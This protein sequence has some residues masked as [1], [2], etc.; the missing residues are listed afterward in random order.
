MPN[1]V[2]IQ[3]IKDALDEEHM[4]SEWESKFLNDIAEFDD[5]RELSAAQNKVLN[6]IGN[7]INRGES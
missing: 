6:R 4:L 2:Q 5:D 7:K 3:I 1:R